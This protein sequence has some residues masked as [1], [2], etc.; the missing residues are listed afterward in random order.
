LEIV[1][2]ENFREWT[3][4]YLPQQMHN[5]PFWNS[6]NSPYKLGGYEKQYLS[7]SYK[8]ITDLWFRP[9]GVSS[10]LMTVSQAV[11]ICILMN[12]NPELVKRPI[13]VWLFAEYCSSIHLDKMH[14]TDVPEVTPTSNPVT[15]LD[16][17]VFDYINSTA[18]ELASDFIRYSTMVNNGEYKKLDNVWDKQQARLEPSKNSANSESWEYQF[19]MLYGSQ[20]PNMSA[21]APH[22]KVLRF[23]SGSCLEWLDLVEAHVTD[24]GKKTVTDENEFKV[25]KSRCESVKA[26]LDGIV[27]S[28]GIDKVHFLNRNLDEGND[29][30]ALGMF[31]SFYRL[32]VNLAQL[33]NSEP[34]ET[35]LD[36]PTLQDFTSVKP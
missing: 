24:E 11:W 13:D 27:D 10:S 31:N 15:A 18:W 14:D 2:Q 9:L 21:L 20:I 8:E 32:M 25:I 23:L 7:K 4:L 33:L 17:S 29:S 6:P 5:N 28:K 1:N 3:K 35:I 19:P 16:S 26:K 22:L 30:F 36:T 34:N 12:T